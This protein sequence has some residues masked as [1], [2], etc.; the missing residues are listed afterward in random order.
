M[1]RGRQTPLPEGRA[2]SLWRG[3]SGPDGRLRHK[4][5]WKDLV[6]RPSERRWRERT[7]SEA[8]GRMEGQALLLTFAATGKSESPGGETGA[9]LTLGNRLGIKPDTQPQPRTI[10]L[11][12]SEITFP[13]NVKSL[14]AKWHPQ[15]QQRQAPHTP[16][17]PAQRQKPQQHDTN[18]PDQPGRNPHATR[19]WRRR[20]TGCSRTGQL[21]AAAIRPKRIDSCQTRS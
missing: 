5:P 13:S 8:Q 21:S 4:G 19:A 15:L 14:S 12:L 1:C 17:P 11:V 3:A 7:R 10:L 16:T 6:C 18:Q 20:A 2:E 9:V